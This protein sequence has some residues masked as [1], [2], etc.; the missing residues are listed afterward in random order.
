[1]T[2]AECAECCVCGDERAVEALDCEG[3][4]SDECRGEYEDGGPFGP[5]YFDAPCFS[6]EPGFADPGGTSALRAASAGNPRN[7]PCP[8]CGAA[9]RLTPADRARGY[10]CDPCADRDERGGY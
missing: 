3:C 4:C 7:L 2:T 9:N 10:Q 1:V 6:G 5:D 8:T